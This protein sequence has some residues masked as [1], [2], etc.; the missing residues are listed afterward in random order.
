MAFDKRTRARLHEHCE[1]LHE[2]DGIDP[3]ELA[4]SEGQ[5]R[6]HDRK[7]LQ[8]CRQ[9]ADTLSLVLAGEF[10]DELLHNLEVVSVE[11]APDASQLLVGVCPAIPGEQVDAAQVMER[12]AKVSGRLRSE[13]AAAITRKRAPRLLFQ[14]L[15]RP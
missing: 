4:K 11:P 2:D 3:R 6:R 14:V 7:T 15:A 13:V 9:V 5:P 8:L 12:L 1:Q 10:D